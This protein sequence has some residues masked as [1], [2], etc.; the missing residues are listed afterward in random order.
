MFFV[1]TSDRHRYFES[2]SEFCYSKR[3]ARLKFFVSFFPLEGERAYLFLTFEAGSLCGKGFLVSGES[4]M[5]RKWKPGSYVCHGVLVVSYLVANQK[6][7]DQEKGAH[8]IY[9]APF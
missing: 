4:P 8:G 5:Q 9:F 6:L 2:G 7:G 1:T 3:T